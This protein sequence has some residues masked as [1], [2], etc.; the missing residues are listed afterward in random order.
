M[1]RS[2]RVRALTPPRVLVAADRIGNLSSGVVGAALARGFC[3]VAQVA[4]VPIAEGGW[5]LAEAVAELAGGQP[6]GSDE[7]WMV[8]AGELILVGVRQPARPLWSA[9][10]STGDLGR[11]VTQAVGAS[12]ATT[13]VLDLTGITAHDGGAGLLA[14]A[15]EALTGR[16]LIAVVPAKE[17]DWPATG[18]RGG[19]VRRAY[20]AGLDVADV[21]SA[22]SVMKL[23]AERLGPGLALAPGGGAAGGTGL[24]V[25]S[26][27]G[28]LLSGAQFCHRLAGLARTLPLADLVVTGCTEL[29]VLDQG[30]SVVS[31]VATWAQEAQVP[32]VAF[33]AG[34]ELARRELRTFGLESAHRVP[35]R[36]SPGELEQAAARVAAG[37]YPAR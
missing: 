6:V 29:S 26:L 7:S 16:E 30:G 27:G 2:D 14:E 13:V 36:P 35:G 34:V 3:E 12:A 37:W 19:L 11:W 18:L 8:A 5:D 23:T 20:P 24:A 31:A 25:L 22:D 33:T 28:R 32:C 10:A 9:D 17:L 4:V 15:A 21:V 1:V